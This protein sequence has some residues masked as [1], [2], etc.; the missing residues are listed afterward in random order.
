VHNGGMAAWSVS[1]TICRRA[2]IDW[3]S[4]T[5]FDHDLKDGSGIWS[6]SLNKRIG[7]LA[8]RFFLLRGADYLEPGR[9]SRAL[10][11]PL[12]YFR[13]YFTFDVQH[14]STHYIYS[15]SGGREIYDTFLNECH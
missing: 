11:S 8:W 7:R 3:F 10:G 9:R 2:S 5:L 14:H 13:I 1:V 12:Y 4:S 15:V 6:L